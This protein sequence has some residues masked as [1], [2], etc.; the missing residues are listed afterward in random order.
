MTDATPDDKSSVQSPFALRLTL[1]HLALGPHYPPSDISAEIGRISI[2]AARADE[3][4]VRLVEVM[5]CGP[6]EDRNTWLM[7]SSGDLRG[8]CRRRIEEL[9]EGE[10]RVEAEATINRMYSALRRR[11]AVLHTIWTLRGKDAMTP[12]S[13]IVSAATEPDPERSLRMLATRE[14]AS[15]D[16]QTL[17]PK[18]R[19]PG[20]ATLD[21]LQVSRNELEEAGRDL[22]NLSFILA[23][24]LYVGTP[25]GARSRFVH[26]VSF[27]TGEQRWERQEITPN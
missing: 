19:G 23:S 11:H 9:F 12:V 27:E 24:A 17:H 2:A 5:N 14:I 21:Q 8:E 10:L 7:K 20:P 16:W 1:D 15:P 18:S 26:H 13:D 22:R 3:E 6:L 4:F 25:P